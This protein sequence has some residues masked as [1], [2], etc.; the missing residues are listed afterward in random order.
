MRKQPASA[1]DEEIGLRIRAARLS[2]G[3]TQGALAAA[4]GIHRQQIERF[5]RGLQHISVERLQRIA[6]ALNVRISEFF[7]DEAAADGEPDIL[8]SLVGMT[9][10]AIALAQCV[11]DLPPET[12]SGIFKIVQ[13]AATVTNTRMPI[14]VIEI[15]GAISRQQLA[16]FVKAHGLQS[17][18]P[19]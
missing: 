13:A 8:G 1:I 18:R 15:P 3:M 10:S 6:K 5:E 2:C 14:P 12:Q 4:V 7:A 9:K 17:R 11:S 19:A 16:E